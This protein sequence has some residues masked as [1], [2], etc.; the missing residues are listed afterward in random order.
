MEIKLVFLERNNQ[1]KAI[2][3]I[4][5]GNEKTVPLNNG[6]IHANDLYSKLYNQG[7]TTIVVEHGSLDLEISATQKHLENLRSIK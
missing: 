2:K 6:Y 7:M 5:P 1:P 3:F 4:T